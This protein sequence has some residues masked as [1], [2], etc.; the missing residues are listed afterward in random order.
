MK[1]H[2]WTA[3][4]FGAIAAIAFL[5]LY[6]VSMY[7]FDRYLDEYGPQKT[8]GI[9]KVA[10][11]LLFTAASGSSFAGA[12]WASPCGRANIL[13][14]VIAAI[15]FIGVWELVFYAV[16]SIAPVN[17]AGIASLLWLACGPAIAM[18]WLVTERAPPN[19]SLE[20]TR[21]R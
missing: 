19:K 9:A 18:Y 16:A 5:G 14:V 8:M 12:Y 20:R 7:S 4:L 13:K 21:G 11:V 1:Q 2:L 10:A 6:A 17:T 3:A 15:F